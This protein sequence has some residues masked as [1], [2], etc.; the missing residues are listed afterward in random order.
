MKLPLISAGEFFELLRPAAFVL[1][2]ALSTWVLAS[3]RRRSFNPYAALAWALGTFFLPSVVLP[4]YLMVLIFRYPTPRSRRSPAET[5]SKPETEPQALPIRHRF[6][7]PAVYGV[8]LLGAMSVYLY[9]DYNSVDA[10][11]ARATQ[12][13]LSSQPAKTIREYRA[14]LALEENPHIHKLLGVELAEAAQWAEAL[15]EFRLAE[16]GG[17]PDESLP[18]RIGQALEASGKG[19]DAE[20]EY[21][22]YLKSQ[23]CNQSL[24]D[25][26]CAVARLRIHQNN[27]HLTTEK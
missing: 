16:I 19:P 5:T 12:A 20:P 7:L 1:S 14:A 18:F 17:E 11:L 15:K 9:R 23:A 3:A 24:P 26:D 25:R 21:A 13:K 27:K 10:H 6:L 22:R 8:V 2:V 4:L